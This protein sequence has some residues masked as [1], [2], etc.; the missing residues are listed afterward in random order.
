MLGN[1]NVALDDIAQIVNG[2]ELFD[3]EA[4]RLSIASAKVPSIRRATGRENSS[5]VEFGHGQVAS[6]DELVTGD[7][8]ALQQ[9]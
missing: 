8:I 2:F 4:A 6:S 9:Y 1:A 7:Q 5:R 3:S